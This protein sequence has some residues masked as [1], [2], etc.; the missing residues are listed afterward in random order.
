MVVNKVSDQQEMKD[1]TI[2]SA[3][4]VNELDDE[5]AMFDEDIAHLAEFTVVSKMKK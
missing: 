3:N 5:F 4:E 2:E 1:I